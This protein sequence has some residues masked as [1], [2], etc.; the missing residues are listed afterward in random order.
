MASVQHLAVRVSDIERSTRFYVETFGGKEVLHPYHTGK[1]MTEIIFG[2]KDTDYRIGFIELPDGFG[3]ELFQFLPDRNPTIG[4]PQPE[5]SFM[6]F[7]IAVDD[8][9]ATLARAVANGGE[10]FGDPAGWAPGDP[11]KY[12][13]VK[14]PDGNILEVNDTTWERILHSA[15]ELYPEARR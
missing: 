8:V 12:A 9:A 2:L 4:V 10:S 1:Q 7:A 15:I 13:Y 6:H 3:L 14:D 5:A 11:A